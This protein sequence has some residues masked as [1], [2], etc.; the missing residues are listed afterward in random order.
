MGHIEVLFLIF[1]RTSILF[2]I[3]AAPVYIPSESAQEFPF[4]RSSSTLVISCL[5]GNSHSNRCEVIFHYGF[6][7]HFPVISD[8]EYIFMYL[9]ASVCHLRKNVFSGSSLMV[10]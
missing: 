2:S 1:G 9:L 5:F 10:Q 8:V 6:D 7:L 3:V 4:L